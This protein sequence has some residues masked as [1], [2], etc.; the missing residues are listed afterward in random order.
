MLQ[1]ETIRV[2]FFVFLFFLPLSLFSSEIKDKGKLAVHLAPKSADF[3]SLKRMDGI[4]AGATEKVKVSLNHQEIKNNRWITTVSISFKHDRPGFLF[5]LLDKV[6]AEQEEGQRKIGNLLWVEL[7]KE[8]GDNIFR[9]SFETALREDAFDIL[10]KLEEIRDTK[11]SEFENLRADGYYKCLLEIEIPDRNEGLKKVARFLND[12]NFNIPFF[13]TPQTDQGRVLMILEV[14]VSK[15]SVWADLN[16]ELISYV[17]ENPE[18]SLKV[19]RKGELVDRILDDLLLPQIAPAGKSEDTFMNGQISHFHK[20]RQNLRNALDIVS[21]KHLSQVRKDRITPYLYHQV[22]IIRI[23]AK[24]FHLF[25][26]VNLDLL[27]RFIGISHDEVYYIL[28]CTALLHDAV[29]DGDVS[30]KTLKANF[31]GKVCLLVSLLSKSSARQSEEEESQYLKDIV[32]NQG[33]LPAL[34]KLIKIADRIQNIRSLTGNAPVFQ[35][36]IFFKTLNHFIPVFLNKIDLTDQHMAPLRPIFENAFQI[37]NEELDKVGKQFGFLDAE[38]RVNPEEEMLYRKEKQ[39][40]KEIRKN[41]GRLNFADYM[42]EVLYGDLGYYTREVSVGKQ[43]FARDNNGFMPSGKPSLARSKSFDTYSEN[44]FFGAC[45]AR[46]VE[47]MWEKMGRPE[48][49]KVVEMGAGR[50]TLARNILS[51]LSENNPVL[52][53]L[54]KYVIVEISPKLINDQKLNFQEHFGSLDKVPVSWI[55]GSATELQ[56]YLNEVEGVFLSNELADQFPVHRLKKDHGEIKEVYICFENGRF[57]EEFGELSSQALKDY[58]GQLNFELPEGAELPVNLNMKEWQGAIAD[59]LKRGFVLTLDYGGKPKAIAQ[60]HPYGVWNKDTHDVEDIYDRTSMCDI[61]SDVNFYDLAAWGGDSG[62]KNEGYTF[63]RD[64]L[65]NLG[66]EDITINN[67]HLSDRDSYDIGTNFN[68]K[69]LAQSKGFAQKTDLDAF[70]INR[71]MF[72]YF[73]SKPIYLSLPVMA[74]NTKYVVMTNASRDLSKDLFLKGK[75]TVEKFLNEDLKGYDPFK[76]QEVIPATAAL[77]DARGH[78]IVKVGRDRLND[79]K[80]WD[81]HGNVLYDSTRFEGRGVTESRNYFLGESLKMFD[82]ST[83][84][85]PALSNFL[86][87]VKNGTLEMMDE[88]GNMKAFFLPYTLNELGY[89]RCFERAS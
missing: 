86:K 30:M 27:S 37:F 59:V 31:D 33:I 5:E 3:N 8:S 45:I 48:N 54:M 15:K 53:R 87:V 4:E 24:E 26:P 85:N 41:G 18:L 51:C 55:Q 28:L 52:Y 39:I 7:Y 70:K 80:V 32:E 46:Q 75:D 6:S 62:L 38:G 49:F 56:S 14:Q 78:Y 67:R 76:F 1:K 69:V 21:I 43:S 16:R 68:F 13:M 40:V 36:K 89:F 88:V 82:L 83:P 2:Y 77:V 35:R 57:Q 84:E 79:L 72:N 71:E 19:F 34:A 25:D 74:Q 58:A 11:N 47:E 65:W 22:D 66:I 50:G 73:Y 29:E 60:A 42:Q 10:K 17:A 20:L 63:Q 61:T 23:I 12:K 44:P 64:F 81:D 9:F